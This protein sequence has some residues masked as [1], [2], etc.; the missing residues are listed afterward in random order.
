MLCVHASLATLLFAA[1]VSL[2]QQP[3]EHVVII[4]IDGLSPRGIDAAFTP[5][6]N[7]L[8]AE[9]S[10]SFDARGVFPTSSGPNWAS[11]LTGATPESHGVL[12]NSWRR[13]SRTIE[14]AATGPEDIFPT[15]F[16]VVRAARSD[17]GIAVIYDWRGIG[18]LF[19]KSVVDLDSDTDGPVATA[20]RAAS[21]F[22]AHTPELMFVHLDHVDGAGHTHGWHTDPYYAAVELADELLGRIVHAVEA[23][24][25]AG[26]T[27]VIISSDHGG[28]GKSHGGET[29]AELTIPWIAWGAGIASGR[30]ITRH[31][32]TTDTAVTAAALLGIEAHPAWTGRAVEEALVGTGYA[33]WVADRYIP[34]PRITP[35][36]D[37]TTSESIDV[38]LRS[39]TPGM[40]LRYTTDGSEP[41]ALSPRYQQPFRVTESTL[42]RARA[43]N[44]G[45]MS[46]VAD[47]H[48]RFVR[49]EPGRGV[50]YE[51]FQLSAPAER[52]PDFGA[53]TPIGRG[54]APEFD[55]RFVES[56]A[57]D[58]FAVRFTALLEIRTP[59]T[60]TFELG[61]DDGSRLFLNNRKL[62]DNDGRHG[63]TFESARID[64]QP[65]EVRLVVEYFDGGGGEELRL[66]YAGP[67]IPRQ[68]VPVDR[69]RPD[70]R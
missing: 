10:Y 7:R 61:S 64:L 66:D 49:A 34:A 68:Q 4:G 3:A 20:E 39:E 12:S 15:V 29:M 33:G 42:V 11:M 21:H 36:G 63:L 37:V 6:F 67:G 52:L 31:V 59:G 16:A 35:A 65:G 44:D 41:T 55:L 23:S 50:A 43:F 70:P 60:Y 40:E 47:A 58:P 13:G 25:A 69:L 27:A 46:A 38:S 53:L 57:S 8:M 51:V 1:S 17:A 45:R 28:I 5:V 18:E 54:V 24:A 32:S 62:I 19:E 56:D 48:F 26:R 9:G 22:T 14:P 30:R 2:G